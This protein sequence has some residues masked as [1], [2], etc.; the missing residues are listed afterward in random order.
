MEREIR[1]SPSSFITRRRPAAGQGSEGGSP[2]K[3]SHAHR[4]QIQILIRYNFFQTEY[5]LLKFSRSW[6]VP[7]TLNSGEFVFKI[8]VFGDSKL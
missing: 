5:F 4:S 3:P 6:A 1:K 2:L 8:I 7:E